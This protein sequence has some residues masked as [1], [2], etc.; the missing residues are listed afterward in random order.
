MSDLRQVVFK[1]TL[2]CDASISEPAKGHIF[3][4]RTLL[5]QKQMDVPVIA[6]SGFHAPE[7]VAGVLTEVVLNEADS[8]FSVFK[9][10]SARNSAER[11]NIMKSRATGGFVKS[12]RSIAS[13]GW[14]YLVSSSSV[15]DS[16]KCPGDVITARKKQTSTVNEIA[17]PSG[18][19]SGV[20]W[21]LS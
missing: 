2:H 11:C 4:G 16:E 7:N 12:W 1:M 21:S 20:V 10:Y 14:G 17:I 9:S 5:L 19:H 8:S 3:I 18:D 6:S 15:P 13:W